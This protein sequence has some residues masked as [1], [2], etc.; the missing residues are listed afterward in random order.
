MGVT[1]ADGD[2]K[3]EISP[4]EIFEVTTDKFLQSPPKFSWDAAS[5]SNALVMCIDPDAPMRNK[6]SVGAKAD[7]WGPWMHFM[8]HGFTDLSEAAEE[9][10]YVGPAPP[11][12]SGLHRYIFVLFEQN[13]S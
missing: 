10:A 7:K 5:A 4:G 12:N 6:A 1:Y 9:F 2:E 8:A 13:G 11:E 3:R